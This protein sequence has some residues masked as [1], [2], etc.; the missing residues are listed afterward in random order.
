M[1]M[2]LP[3]YFQFIAAL[4]SCGEPEWANYR[5]VVSACRR[6]INLCTPRYFYGIIL[7]LRLL[8]DNC[9]KYIFDSEYYLRNVSLWKP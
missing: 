8:G 3:L 4:S 7:H 6:C 5:V 9:C 2:D 1:R